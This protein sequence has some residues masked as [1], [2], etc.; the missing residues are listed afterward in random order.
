MFTWSMKFVGVIALIYLS[1][2]QEQS[3]VLVTAWVVLEFAW[4]SL[5]N[6]LVHPSSSNRRLD[7]L[8]KLPL[9]SL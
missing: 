3:L 4:E 9:E 5:A 1:H 6:D 2:C 8:L 7:W